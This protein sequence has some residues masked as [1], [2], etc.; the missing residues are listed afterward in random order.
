MLDEKPPSSTEFVVKSLEV[1]L[2][3][4]SDLGKNN[5]WGRKILLDEKSP[6]STGFVVQSFELCEVYFF[7]VDQLIARYLSNFI[8]FGQVI[9]RIDC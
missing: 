7:L 3:K 9:V 4:N 6:S 8:P 5:L 1:V 2:M